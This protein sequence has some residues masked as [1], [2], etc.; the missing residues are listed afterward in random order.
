[1]KNLLDAI[2][3]DISQDLLNENAAYKMA[4]DVED[5]SDSLESLRRKLEKWLK[6][7]KLK[8]VYISPEDKNVKN[9]FEL[10]LSKIEDAS[11]ILNAIHNDLMN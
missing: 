9:N 1:M 4:S 7:A 2:G 3:E 8:D 5:F 10:A 11:T 6:K